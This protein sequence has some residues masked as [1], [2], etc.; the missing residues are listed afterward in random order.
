MFITCRIISTLIESFVETP[1]NNHSKI[2]VE[3]LLST[4][5][6]YKYMVISTKNL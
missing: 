6:V 2:G 1:R 4:K 3:E 5:Q